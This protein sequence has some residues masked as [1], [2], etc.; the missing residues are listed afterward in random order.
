[1]CKILLSINPEHVDNILSGKKMYE[2]RKIQCK[3]KVDK[4]VIYSTFPVMKVVGEADVE[5][6]IVDE[7]ESV[8]NITSE[9]SGITKIF[10]D[11][12]YKNKD[13]AVA[14]KLSNVIKYEQPKSLSNYGIK[15]APQSFVYI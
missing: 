4:I 10:F 3:E 14:Y 15:C 8:W 13:K 6:I 7:P 9:Y 11:K 2:F 12:Y 1:M 5:D